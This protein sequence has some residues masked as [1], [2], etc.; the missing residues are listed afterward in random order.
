MAT[1]G[2]PGPSDDQAESASATGPGDS[3]AGSAQDVQ[4]S[5]TG[6]TF[7]DPF[8]SEPPAIEPT[9]PPNSLTNN[10][11][12][13]D[14]PLKKKST[15][16]VSMTKESDSK[17]AGPKATDS[18]TPQT[19]SNPPQVDESAKGASGSQANQPQKLDAA[20]GQDLG[21]NEPRRVEL[22]GTDE[23]PETQRS[24]VDDSELATTTTPLAPLNSPHH[25][26]D[27]TPK[28]ILKKT[29][30]TAAEARQAEEGGMPSWGQF[31]RDGVSEPKD[32]S[33]GTKLFRETIAKYKAAR[34]SKKVEEDVV[35]RLNTETKSEAGTPRLNMELNAISGGDSN[36]E[37]G[38]R[39]R[40][41]CL[42]RCTLLCFSGS[43]G[44]DADG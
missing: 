23:V 5:E 10:P 29:V 37:S 14:K 27:I 1:Q 19:P 15:S 20:K 9:G 28:S 17:A 13:K 11:T 22:G 25:R 12:A 33:A 21:S 38:D 18:V 39:A 24:N 40:K 4:A 3:A 31:G 7:L 42:P 2:D 6:P 16:Q 44:D 30:G 41:C 26:H 36:G 35:S 43:E 32:P 8:D 34:N